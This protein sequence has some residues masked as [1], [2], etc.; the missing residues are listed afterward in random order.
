M[1][2]DTPRNRLIRQ[3]RPVRSAGAARPAA[4]RSEGPAPSGSALEAL[5]AA[6]D[7]L[8]RQEA[9]DEGLQ[10]DA[11]ELLGIGQ[12]V[13]AAVDRPGV[14]GGRVVEVLGKEVPE[15]A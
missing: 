8:D 6:V 9:L 14:G 15:R 5:A 4:S 12:K 7:L 13:P 1:G 10:V 2:V 3:P 11:G